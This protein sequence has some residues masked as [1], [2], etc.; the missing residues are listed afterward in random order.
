MIIY[1][2][3]LNLGYRTQIK[4]KPKEFQDRSNKYHPLKANGQNNG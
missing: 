1:F 4:S 3:L 2:N